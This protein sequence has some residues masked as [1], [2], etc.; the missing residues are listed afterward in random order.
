MNEIHVLPVEYLGATIELPLTIITRGYTYQLQIEIEGKKLVFEKDDQ[1]EYRVVDDA[2]GAGHV[3][4]S[5]VLAI[6][7]TL[8]E[9]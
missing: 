2:N 1:G 9:L 8:R 5:L 6:L 7:S 4:K 3:N